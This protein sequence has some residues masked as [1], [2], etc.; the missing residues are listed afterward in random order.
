MSPLNEIAV[1]DRIVPP[2]R[3]A[4]AR[5]E[6]ITESGKI[7]YKLE[8]TWEF[9]CCDKKDARLPEAMGLEK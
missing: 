1:G 8:G 3:F 4:Y 6:S 7:F 5:V 9:G 2:G